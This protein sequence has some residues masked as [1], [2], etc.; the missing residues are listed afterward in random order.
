ML[1]FSRDVVVNI[2]IAGTLDRW[3]NMYDNERNEGHDTE[4]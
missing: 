3:C 4:L 2:V 1:T